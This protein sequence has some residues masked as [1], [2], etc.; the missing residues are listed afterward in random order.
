MCI[1]KDR[2]FNKVQYAIGIKASK[3]D[4]DLKD[5]KPISFNKLM[6]DKNDKDTEG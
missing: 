1:S 3:G 6:E 5:K 2:E 4:S